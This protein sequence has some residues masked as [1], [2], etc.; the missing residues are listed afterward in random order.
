MNGWIIWL[1]NILKEFSI[2]NYRIMIH[3][4]LKGCTVIPA[5]S[6]CLTDHKNGLLTI[7]S[8]IVI[9]YSQ[10]K[11]VCKSN[12]IDDQQPNSWTIEQLII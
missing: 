6:S 3:N 12:L 7:G 2:T 10:K 4:Y 9:I 11:N 5:T 8:K 1:S